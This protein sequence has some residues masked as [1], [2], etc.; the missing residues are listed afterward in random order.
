MST[1]PSIFLLIRMCVTSTTGS[2]TLGMTGETDPG[3]GF[4]LGAP[5]VFQIQRR[6][7]KASV[8]AA[9]PDPR[10]CV[11]LFVLLF[12]IMKSILVLGS[13]AW[14]HSV[15]KNTL[16]KKTSLGG[17]SDGGGSCGRSAR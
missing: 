13:S 11:V 8:V 3:V 10:R 6:P 15:S 14:T 1:A 17:A 5:P 2:K 12:F 4:P 7:N 16:K 9:R